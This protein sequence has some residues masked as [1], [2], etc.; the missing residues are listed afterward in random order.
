MGLLDWVCTLRDILSFEKQAMRQR[1]DIIAQNRTLI[2]LG[3]E[4]I[5]RLDRII[6][7]QPKVDKLIV[8][9]QAPVTRQEE[10]PMKILLLKKS[11][12]PAHKFAAHKAGDAPP[13]NFALVDNEDDT[14][15]VSGMRDDGTVVDLSSVATLG[16]LSSSDPT[17]MTADS[18][19]GMTWVE[20][21]LAPTDPGD[22]TATPPVAPTPVEITGIVTWNDGSV[23]PLSYTDPVTITAP[24]PGPVTKL[25]VS[26]GTPVVRNV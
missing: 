16:S 14:A 19:N 13:T 21:A 20:H 9:H 8:T 18:I 5:K 26:H 7:N 17:K 24:P 23:G 25:V 12:I 15:T 1:E 3:R 6:A 22:P 10:K 11:Q 2:A 4:E